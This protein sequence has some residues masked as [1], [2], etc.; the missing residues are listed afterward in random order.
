MHGVIFFMFYVSSVSKIMLRRR[1]KM[2][3]CHLHLFRKFFYNRNKIPCD[4]ICI[5]KLTLLKKPGN[6]SVNVSRKSARL[7]L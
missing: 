3:D 4:L 2:R 6:L 7:H 1:L 5:A